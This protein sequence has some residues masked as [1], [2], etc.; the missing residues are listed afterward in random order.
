[1]L[2][3]RQ[4]VSACLDFRAVGMADPDG[5]QD[6]SERVREVRRMKRRGAQPFRS[7]RRRTQQCSIRHDLRGVQW[8]G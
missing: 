4:L 6:E 1:M 2:K 8:S 3:W 7:R 5:V